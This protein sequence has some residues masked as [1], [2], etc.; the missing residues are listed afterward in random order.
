MARSRSVATPRSRSTKAQIRFAPDILRRLGEELNPS[1]DQGILELV[2]NSFDADALNCTVELLDTDDIGGTVRV[3]DDGDGM[4][5]KAIVDGW[6]VCGRSTKESRRR[7]RLGRIPAGSKGLGRLASLRMGAR[8][9]LRT[10]PRKDK[11]SQYEL[12]IPWDQYDDVNLVEDVALTVNHRQ[13]RPRE[14]NGTVI[15]IEDLRTHIGRMDV[16]RLARA[17]ILLAD[18]F[19][20]DPAGF[21][22]ILIAPEFS[23][24]EELVQQRYFQDAEYHL[25]AAVDGR[26]KARASVVDG[27]GEQLFKATHEEL[28]VGRDDGYTYDCPPAKFDLWV[29]LLSKSS[30][31]SRSASLSEVREW[32]QAFGGVHFYQ[33]GLRVNPYGNAGNDWLDMN[34]RRAQSPEERPSTNTSIGRISLDDPEELLIQKTDRSGFIEDDVFQEIR[35]FAHDA[36]EW[37]ARRRIEVAE[38]RRA[39]ARTAAPRRASKSKKALDEAIDRA[40]KKAQDDLRKAAEAYDRSRKREVEQLRQEVQLYRTLS[41]AGITAATFA[42]DSPIKAITLAINAIERQT[43]KKFGTEYNRALKKPVERVKRA[44]ARLGVLDRATLKLLDHE[45]RRPGRVEPHEII[46]RLLE[47]YKPFLDGRKVTPKCQ[48]CSGNPYLRAT[49]A[50]IESIVTNLINNSITALE[51]ASGDR[52]LRIRTEVEEDVFSIRVL[53]NGPGIVDI[54][55]RDMW[56]PGHTTRQNGTGL[57]LTIVRDSVSDLGGAVSAVENSELGGAEIVVELPILGV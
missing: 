11:T 51:Q 48:F 41:T 22:P 20:E 43:K 1:P 35:S 46:E 9:V 34:L 47:T 37:L 4:H 32:L 40:P 38:K 56:L 57:G 49:E 53:D 26:G 29:F 2:R 31:V 27:R 16:K 44:T 8:A 3:T 36:M 17:M 55:I 39:K 33:N 6:L 7:T 25:I 52:L 19:G 14:G 10:R 12:T 28:T 13:R 21:S 54:A 18:P 45:K 15:E 5:L 30:F 23:D 24:L 50:A 42:H